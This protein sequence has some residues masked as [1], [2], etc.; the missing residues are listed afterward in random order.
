[1]KMDNGARLSGINHKLH[2]NATNSCTSKHVKNPA[3]LPGG[4]G[5]CPMLAVIST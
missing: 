4:V 5:Y 3:K 1:M 2:G